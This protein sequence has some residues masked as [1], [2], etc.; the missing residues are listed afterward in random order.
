MK[1]I[2]VNKLNIIFRADSSSTI[3]TGHI[4]RD[5]VLAK[6]Y[7]NADITFVTLDLEG[8]LNKK[9]KDEGYKLKLLNSNDVEE[10][11]KVVKGLKADKVIVDNYS[12][13]A[14]YEKQL[15]D[16]TGVRV[17]VLDDTYE[18]HHCDIVLNHN[19][20]ADAS[21]YKNLV[22]KNCEL[23]CGAK[24]TL[25]RDEFVKAKQKNYKKSKKFTVFLAMGGADTAGLNIVLLKALKNF[26]NIK[27]HL[28]TTDANQNLKKLKRYVKDKSWI[29]LHIN[30]T[31]VAKLMA[32]SHLAVVTPSGVLNEVHFMGIP[33][34]VIQS[35]Q[36]QNFMSEY[37]KGHLWR[38]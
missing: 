32:K 16:A 2:C 23:R 24:Y 6:E 35:A 13:D 20:Y 10:F 31:K 34:F 15:K 27:V 37:L 7:K 21:R 1:K 26:Q 29:K 14:K 9:I 36:N 28:V 33:F 3:G 18:K 12:I 25:L 22:P 19:I 5:L 11:I 8:S 30:S 17:M 38:V 4:M